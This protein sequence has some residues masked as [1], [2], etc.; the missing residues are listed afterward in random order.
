[1]ASGNFFGFDTSLPEN[2]FD[3]MDNF[4]RED[5]E[6]DSRNNLTFGAGAVPD[7]VSSALDSALAMGDDFD[8][9]L[10]TD[11]NTL[12]EDGDF[13]AG[14]LSGQSVFSIDTS[15]AWSKP[16]LL[17]PDEIERSA[18][19][20][21]G[22]DAFASGS[23]SGSGSL[24]RSHVGRGERCSRFGPRVHGRGSGRVLR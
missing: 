13:G 16:M 18:R 12:M 11:L 15:A 10:E 8:F 1:M 3:A 9:N 4:A 23:G 21:A 17:T 6:M 22:A 14:G 19:A 24:T 7:I 5:P 20:A 2:E